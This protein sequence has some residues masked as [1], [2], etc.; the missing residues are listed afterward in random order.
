[1]DVYRVFSLYLRTHM[2]LV[3]PKPKIIDVHCR[4]DLKQ[5]TSVHLFAYLLS[6][7]PSDLKHADAFI[8]SLE[9]KQIMESSDNNKNKYKNP[10]LDL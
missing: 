1:M 4:D 5:T 6:H 3:H 8:E 2:P 7:K 10:T 9:F